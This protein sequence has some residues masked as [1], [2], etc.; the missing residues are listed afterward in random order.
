MAYYGVKSK[1]KY[2]T[3]VNQKK[4][5]T[6]RKIENDLYYRGKD[7]LILNIYTKLNIIVRNI[8]YTTNYLLYHLLCYDPND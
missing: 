5:F 4:Y 7:L 2:F 6:E 3:G 8:K 1:Q